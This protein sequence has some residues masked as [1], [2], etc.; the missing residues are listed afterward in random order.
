MDGKKFA[1]MTFV[2]SGETTSHNFEKWK[3]DVLTTTAFD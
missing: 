2:H 1:E 3:L